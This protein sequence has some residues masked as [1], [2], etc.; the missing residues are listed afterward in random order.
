MPKTDLSSATE[1]RRAGWMQTV[2]GAVLREM[3]E[4]TARRDILSF[5]LGLP[6]PELFPA[7]ACA[8][9]A[10]QALSS[11]PLTL[12]YGPPFRP[13]RTQI[14]ELMAL[15]GVNCD[16]DQVFLTT[17]A[18]QGTH[19]LVRMLLDQGEQVFCEELTYTGFRQIIEPF[20]PEVMTIPTD[21]ETGMDVD[22][23]EWRLASGARPAFIYAIPDGHNPLSVSMSL[24]KRERLVALAEQYRVPI[25]E[26][27]VYGFLCYETPAAP[28]LHALNPQ[29]VFYVG[30]FSKILAPSLRT[31]WM[32]VP[33]D[34][35]PSLSIVK[36]AT[37]LDTS[38]FNQRLISAYISAKR[39]LDHVT[40]LRQAY[41]L[42]RD[43]MLN[44]LERHFPDCAS[45]IKPKTGVFIWVV[46]P[47]EVDTGEL[48]KESVER[49]RIA[50]L[51]GHAFSILYN[52]D[53]ANCMRL[54]FSNSSPAR[55][56]EGIERLGRILKE[57]LAGHPSAEVMRSSG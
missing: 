41:R 18:Q 12:Q 8:E 31:G 40:D 20:Q 16:E 7:E 51:P 50:F 10:A 52:R 43:T 48:L 11:D 47:P 14:A 15:R 1:I 34:L 38:S 27:D 32:I 29:W 19:L 42:R 23:V 35:I 22:F 4:L 36:E 30:S 17:G 49:E 33:Q 25:I 45:W 2:S 3:L 24:A 57:T 21:L 26:D 44:A 46:L 39:L 13:L 28:P 5:A 54:N 6:A 53:A 56:E 55:I 37:D 9:A